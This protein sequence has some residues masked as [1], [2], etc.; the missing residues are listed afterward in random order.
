MERWLEAENGEQLN[1]DGLASLKV[2]S[3]IEK[4]LA[5]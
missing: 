5:F 1:S 3:V 2:W 4:R